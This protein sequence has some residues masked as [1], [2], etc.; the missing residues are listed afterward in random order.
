MSGV[1]SG[2]ASNK[3]RPSKAVRTAARAM[4]WMRV[5]APGRGRLDVNRYE[6][7]LGFRGWLIASTATLKDVLHPDSM[8]AP[9]RV[10]K[11]SQREEGRKYMSRGRAHTIDNF[12]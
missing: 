1:A 11:R 3:P 10:G 2:G 7:P 9:A 5:S 6:V 4:V 12:A 8:M